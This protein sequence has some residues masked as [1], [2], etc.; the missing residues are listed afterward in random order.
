MLVEGV[1]IITP[2]LLR[3]T[4]GARHVGSQ[5]NA[6]VEASSGQLAAEFA[7]IRG[8]LW[9]ENVQCRMNSVEAGGKGISKDALNGVLR[10][11]RDA[12]ILAPLSPIIWASCARACSVGDL[13]CA[14]RF[15]KMSYYTGPYVT[16]A[17]PDRLRAAVRLELSKNPDL[18]SFITGDLRLILT[19]QP[20][21]KPEMMSAYNSALPQN[22]AIL[23]A[24][25]REVDPSFLKENQ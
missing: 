9:A 22:K 3:H 6:C 7:G 13:D 5:Q 21:L 11:C 14:S 25:I 4:V 12:L 17:I 8:D 23:S 15:V 18:E 10:S 19:N 16:A 2:Q 20:N 24:A 1:W